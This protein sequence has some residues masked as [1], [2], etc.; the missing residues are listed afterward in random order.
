MQE[1][2]VQEIENVAVSIGSLKALLG[3]SEIEDDDWE[4]ISSILDEFS[5]RLQTSVAGIRAGIHER[6]FDRHVP[7]GAGDNHVCC[8][9]GCG[10][11]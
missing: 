4:N 5:L 11:H 2:H 8:G 3:I 6:E 10:S 1:S 9:N 7:D